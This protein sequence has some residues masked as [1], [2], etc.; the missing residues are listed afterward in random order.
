MEGEGREAVRMERGGRKQ[1]FYDLSGLT[2][3]EL[4]RAMMKNKHTE[5]KQNTS[6]AYQA[7]QQ[8]S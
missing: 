5:K 7:L 6:Q 4:S 1:G 8:Q 2:I 3:F